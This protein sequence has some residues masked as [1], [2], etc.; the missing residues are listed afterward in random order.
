M[1]DQNRK[2]RPLLEVIACSV[3]DAV[4]AEKGGADRLEIVRDLQRG[5]LT[6]SRELVAEIK[7]AVDLPVRVMLR[8]SD[9]YGIG[10]EDE[11]ERLCLDAERFASLE[12][13]GF[14]L[15]FLKD[16][17]VDVE[18]TRRVLACAPQMRATFHHAFEDANDKLKALSAIKQLAQI[19]RVLS[20]GGTDALRSR[21]QRLGEYERAAAP[22]LVILAG[23]G[24]DSEAILKIGSETGIREFHVGRAARARFDVEGAVQASLVNDLVKNLREI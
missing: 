3:A 5:G 12:V 9:G 22:E 13:D 11:I 2:E 24:I 20:H 4:E 18:L 19:D 16:G 6:P 23:G 14:V 8:E 21:V 1:P 10:N 15:G 7:R 17:E